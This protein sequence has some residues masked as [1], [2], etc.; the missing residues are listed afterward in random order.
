MNITLI[1]PYE[2]GR[3]PFGLAEP[4]ALLEQAGCTVSCCDLSIQQLEPCIDSDADV[5]AIYIA[6]HTATR[7][8]IEALPEIQKIAPGAKLCVYGLYAPMN[9]KLFRSLGVQFIIGGE[10][11]N[12]LLE[13]VEQLRTGQAAGDLAP[14]IR[15]E[16][17]AFI[18]PDRSKLPALSQYAG[19]IMPDG[20]RKTVG[21]AE[22]TRG[23]KYFCRH[24]PVV[25]VY[26]GRFFVIPADIVLADIRA[27][28]AAGAEHISFG[29]PDFFNG[30]GHAMRIVRAMHDEFP[31]LSFDATIKIEHIVKYP[32][33]IH[34]LAAS[35]C[36]FI[37][38]AVEAVDDDILLKLDK[39]HTRAD[40]HTALELMQ[41]AGL[42]LAPT[43]V[44]FTPWTT[45]DNYRELL[46]HIADLQLIEAV[47]PVQLSIRLL[48]PA[49]SHI[50]KLPGMA[51]QV[52]RFD[53]QL[54][55]HPWRNSD[56][57][58][59]AL[60]QSVQEW[61]TQAEADGMSRPDIFQG[62][63][64]RAWSDAGSGAPELTLDGTGK[65]IPRLSENWYCCAEPTCEQLAPF[66][67]TIDCS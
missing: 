9:A 14:L 32:D 62:I 31:Q 55:G 36:L 48:I 56:P 45:L 40:L 3:Q 59:D 4:A 38:A 18:L 42:A 64:Q 12:G 65:P 47:A 37:L 19:L 2:L 63:Y 43:F 8:A 15:M 46:Q 23:C 24:C 5:I 17:T 20:T 22:T 51:A 33:K 1:N 61:V 44:A 10:F 26:E 25:P 67:L 6:M 52:G 28:V 39:G 54:L 53:P 50:L 27:Q 34:E 30:P 49:G 21:F 11:E 29:D 60:Q 58:V 35:G 57:R 41:A 7:I 13:M 66:Q 16:N